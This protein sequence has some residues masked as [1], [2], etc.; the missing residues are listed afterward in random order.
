MG[1]PGGE[2]SHS[3]EPNG[4]GELFVQLVEAFNI[5]R[6]LSAHVVERRGEQAD[7]IVAPTQGDL[8]AVIAFGHLNGGERYSLE[9]ARD[10]S[11][12]E[13]YQQEIRYECRDYA[14]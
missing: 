10:R 5:R 6:H 4:P 2:G 3:G 12:H 11:N 14:E 8:G 7:L 9:R 13:Q 1:D